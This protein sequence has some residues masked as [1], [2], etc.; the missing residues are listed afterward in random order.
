[1]YPVYGGDFKDTNNIGINESTK[2]NLSATKVIDLDK[3][4]SGH[5][6]Y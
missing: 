1:M 5:W 4:R 3:L 2:T 6:S